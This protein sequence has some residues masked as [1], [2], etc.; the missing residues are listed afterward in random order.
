MEKVIR[1]HLIKPILDRVSYE[2]LSN[3]Q[4]GVTVNIR[5]EDDLDIRKVSE[6][7]VNVTMERRVIVSPESIMKL[8]V[9]MM[10]EIPIDSIEF[11]KL[12]DPK[13]YIMASQPVRVLIGYVSNMVS[14]LT[15]NSNIGPIVTPPVIAE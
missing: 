12:E 10:I 6:E 14:N 15:V 8:S 2:R 13:A 7:L 5:P 1:P 4:N 9:R 11:G 3:P